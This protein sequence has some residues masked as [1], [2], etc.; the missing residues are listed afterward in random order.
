MTRARGESS[1]RE[2]KQDTQKENTNTEAGAATTG[3]VCHE[4]A[5]TNPVPFREATD[6]QVTS[7]PNY[8]T[9]K[10]GAGGSQGDGPQ[11][12]QEE[13]TKGQRLARDVRRAGWAMALIPATMAATRM[14]RYD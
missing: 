4:P 1:L 2:A 11:L 5:H 3:L 9:T 10:Q 7:R 13:I 6:F 12:T 14:T 8:R